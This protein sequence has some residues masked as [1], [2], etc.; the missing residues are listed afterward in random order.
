[1][2]ANEPEKIPF[3]IVSL[4]PCIASIFDPSIHFIRCVA[5]PATARIGGTCQFED[6]RRGGRLDRHATVDPFFPGDWL[7]Q[8]LSIP[9]G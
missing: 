8:S 9:N 2:S 6:S 4:L 5:I 3:G 1:M 7:T